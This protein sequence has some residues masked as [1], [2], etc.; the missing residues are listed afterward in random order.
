MYTDFSSSLLRNWQKVLQS[1]SIQFFLLLILIQ[2]W[3]KC[4]I[5][6]TIF[7]KLLFEKQIGIS[8]VD[9][10]QWVLDFFSSSNSIGTYFIGRNYG[11]W[12]LLI[13]L[14][15]SNIS[16]N[17]YNVSIFKRVIFLKSQNYFC[18][19]WHCLLFRISGLVRN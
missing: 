18:S 3:Y 12:V 16:S 6:D 14:K 2:S 8:M 17:Y 4:H 10:R 1:L 15:H 11:S 19:L 5:T 7:S 13:S 9:W